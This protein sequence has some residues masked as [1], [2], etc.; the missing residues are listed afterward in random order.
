MALVYCQ[1]ILSYDQRIALDGAPA[2]LRHQGQGVGGQTA[3]GAMAHK[4]AKH[5]AKISMSDVVTA[6]PHAT[7]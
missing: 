2:D 1:A 3:C 4:A 5:K 6:A 7:G